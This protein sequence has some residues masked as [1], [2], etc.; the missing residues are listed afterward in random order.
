MNEAG[1]VD[2]LGRGTDMNQQYQMVVKKVARKAVQYVALLIGGE[3]SI[4]RFVRPSLEGNHFKIVEAENGVEGLALTFFHKPELILL[5][6]G[7]SDMD[8]LVVLRRLRE[9]TRVP[10]IILT[11]QT[12]EAS[13]IEGLD[14]GADDYLTKPFSVEELM[15]RIRMTLK[16][17]NQS[18]QPEVEPVFQTPDLKVDLA[19]R[20]VIVRG[21][22]VC[23]T[24]VEFHILACL[25]RSAGKVVTPKHLQNYVWGPLLGGKETGLWLYIH[26]L[27]QKI[28][29][30]WTRPK[31]ILTEP[32][33]GYR[34]KYD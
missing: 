22:V 16:Y 6:L 34:L 11:A 15:A 30:E 21:K 12:H 8:G 25:V 17:L 10:I 3:K 18:T 33:V 2:W 4:R 29:V 28:E 23:L 7:L 1:S 20:I 13:K 32:G 19:G 31:Y 26:Q 9:R 14:A 24:P 5:D 27:R